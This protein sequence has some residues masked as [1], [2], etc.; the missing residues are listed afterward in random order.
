MGLVTVCTTDWFNVAVKLPEGYSLPPDCDRYRWVL[1]T[2]SVAKDMKEVVVD[3]VFVFSREMALDFDY[4]LYDLMINL[5]LSQLR[6]DKGVTHRNYFRGAGDVE[7]HLGISDPGSDGCNISVHPLLNHTGREKVL[8][9]AF[10]PKNTSLQD[11][12]YHQEDLQEREKEILEHINLDIAARNQR[13][14][15]PNKLIFVTDCDPKDF[16]DSE[17]FEKFLKENDE[18]ITEMSKSINGSL[19]SK[20]KINAD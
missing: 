14:Q 20:V 13:S 6:V 8:F 7:E 2:G 11:I 19:C 16:G 4:E 9:N 17:D 5:T 18:R 12:R 3:K 10:F 15:Q 1:V